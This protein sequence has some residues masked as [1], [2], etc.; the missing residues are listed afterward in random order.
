VQDL[1]LNIVS[2]LLWPL[3]NIVWNAGAKLYWLY[4]LGA[5]A[6]AFA[7]YLWRAPDRSLARG[8]R[9][10]FPR[11]VFLHPS[12]IADYK[13][14]FANSALTLAV[15]LPYMLVSSTTTA[16]AVHHGLAAATGLPGLGWHGG[17]GAVAAYTLLNLLAIDAAFFVAHYLQHRVPVLW[18]FHKTHHSAEV[19]TPFTVERMHPVDQL[20]NFTMAAM[21][22][23][24]VA[25]VF[26]FLYAGPLTTVAVNGLNIGLF[27]FYLFGV[28]LRHSHVWLMFPPWL[29]RHT[30][31]ARPCI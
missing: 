29:A 17:W 3:A 26:A 24:A 16:A 13:I 20:L 23:G 12:A 22:P 25:G 4:L 11:K 10:V 8:L 7:V 1:G 9:F 21:L 6:M 5:A 2:G 15:M 30:S 27:L 31:A 18:E 14:L 19:L 28:H